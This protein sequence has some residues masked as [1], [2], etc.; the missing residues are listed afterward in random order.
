L[1]TP[2]EVVVLLGGLAFQVTDN[3]QGDEKTIYMPSK[4]LGK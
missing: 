4:R 3:A 1:S 2:G